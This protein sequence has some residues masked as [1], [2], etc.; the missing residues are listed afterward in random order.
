MEPE[1]WFLVSFLIHKVTHNFSIYP[2][3]LTDLAS[4]TRLNDNTL[5]SLHPPTYIL[6]HTES[7]LM[8]LFPNLPHNIYPIFPVKS[9]V[10]A[11]RTR[12]NRKQI[13]ISPGF[14]YTEYKV[15]GA[16]FKSATLDLRRKTIKKTTES[17]KRFCSIYVQ[18]SRV[19]SLEG[20][21]LLEPISL[22]DI[23]DQPHHEL[24]TE[25]ERLQKLGDITLS[26]FTN[27][28]AQ[29]RRYMQ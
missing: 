10:T 25:D 1:H 5:L 11:K 23:N 27:A 7:A 20:V 28:A 24:Q 18:L 9:T 29:R 21:S 4:Y 12:L 17:H 8:V 16:M 13:G 22:D 3:L 15:Q 26:S 14:A 2:I 6:L 19:Q